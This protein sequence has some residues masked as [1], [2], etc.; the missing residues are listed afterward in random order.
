MSK[1]PSPKNVIIEYEKP[2][3]VAIRQVIEEGIFRVDPLTYQS[4]SRGEVRIVDRITDLPIENS[5]ILAQL[6]MEA[7]KLNEK[8]RNNIYSNILTTSSIL[9]S[10]NSS[11]KNEPDKRSFNG[12]KRGSKNFSEMGLMESNIFS[13]TQHISL[14]ANSFYNSNDNYEYETITTSVPESL[15]QKIIAEAR[16]AGIT[17]RAAQQNC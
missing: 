3:A 16:A 17:H 9:N 7:A 13:P 2:K 12:S 8:N 15:A 11:N 14:N 1:T 6:D 10:E 5:R 4:S